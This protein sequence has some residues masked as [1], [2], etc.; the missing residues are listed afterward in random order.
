M[1]RSL[2]LG[3]V[4]TLL[5][6]TLPNAAWA[7]KCARALD[8]PP[9]GSPEAVSASLEGSDFVFTGKVTR[10]PSRIRMYL[11]IARYRWKTR[12]DRELSEEEEDRMFLRCIRFVVETPFK[13][14]TEKNFEIDTGWGTGDCGYD[15]RRGERYLVYATRWDGGAYTGICHATKPLSEAGG[16]VE[17]LRSLDR[18]ADEA[19]GP[20]QFS[21]GAGM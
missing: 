7:C 19:L 15:F 11:Q 4:F 13:G 8:A 12:G 1:N 17:I 20:E 6:L 10:I 21:G 3:A 16:E 2:I 5:L 9:E 14:V 18:G